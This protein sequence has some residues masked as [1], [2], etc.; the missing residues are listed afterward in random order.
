MFAYDQSGQDHASINIFFCRRACEAG[1]L[2]IALT[3]MSRVRRQ[4]CRLAPFPRSHGSWPPLF[5]WWHR[6]SYDCNNPTQQH[7]S[8]GITPGGSAPWQS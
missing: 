1:R 8:F 3:R 6:K 2:G 4:L 7:G 5:Q